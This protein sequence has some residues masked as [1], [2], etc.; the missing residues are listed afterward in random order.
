MQDVFNKYLEEIGIKINENYVDSQLE[1]LKLF[2]SHVESIDYIVMTDMYS[3]LIHYRNKPPM[4]SM[5]GKKE[6]EI[7]KKLCDLCDKKITE[8]DGRI[9][10]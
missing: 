3:I 9:N 1:E 2:N 5:V 4:A 8:I 10:E 6:F 7:Y